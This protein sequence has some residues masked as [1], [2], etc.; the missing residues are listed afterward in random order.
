[1]LEIGIRG[2]TCA[3]CAGRVERAVQKVRGRHDHEQRG[4][5]HSRYPCR[6]AQ[7]LAHH[8]DE[9]FLGV[10]L[11]RHADSRGG[12]RSVSGSVLLAFALLG[13]LAPA[14]HAQDNLV[15]VTVEGG[16]ALVQ[17]R[18]EALE[19]IPLGTGPHNLALSPERSH[20]WVTDAAASK[21]W[22][23]DT[24]GSTIR[25]LPGAGR[26]PHGLA[27]SSDGERAVLAYEDD[28]LVALFDAGTLRPLG[29]LRLP[30]PP[31]NAALTPDGREAWLTA[32]SVNRI[33]VVDLAS[34]RLVALMRI[35]GGPHDLAFTPDGR[36]LWV[37]LWGS[38]EVAVVDVKAR[39][40]AARV[41]AGSVPHHLAVTPDGS[42]VW[43]T[44]HHSGDLSVFDR[45]TRRLLRHVAVGDSP[46]HVA[47]SADSRTAYVVSEG[48][49]E[50][51]VIALAGEVQRRVPVG[52]RPHGVAVR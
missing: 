4:A 44:N 45:K 35:A 39:K 48:A 21:V 41:R 7:D 47:F 52:L 10:L 49:G 36:E 51:L 50:L 24:K 17:M 26:D 6:G 20:A 19:R 34:M 8:P 37:T 27:L 28:R 33:L 38:N 1:M 9:S 25:E 11:Q 2:M 42:E 14:A 12:R 31:H 5:K 15:V 23:V 29:E 3:A 13:A 43:V 22:V 18:G 40:L 30:V 32:P 46:H 16:G